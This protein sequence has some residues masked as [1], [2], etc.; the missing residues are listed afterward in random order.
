MQKVVKLGL[1]LLIVTAVSAGA[2]SVTN[3][4]TKDIIEQKLLKQT[5]HI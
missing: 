3:N 4:F 2:L 1:I 5:S